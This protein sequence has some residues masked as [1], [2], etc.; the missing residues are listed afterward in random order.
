MRVRLWAADFSDGAAQ[1][2]EKDAREILPDT[3]VPLHYDLQLSPNAAAL[4]FSG[5][6][7]ITVQVNAPVNEITVNADGL[8]F[9]NATLDQTALMLTAPDAKLGRETMRA[10]KPIAAGQ[11]ILT[12]DYSGP[13]TRN[14]LGFFAMDYQSASGPRRTLATNLE[15]TGARKVLP[16][17]DEPA[18]KATFTI[19]VDAPKSDGRLQH[20]VDQVT[21]LPGDLQRVRFKQTPK[22]STYLLF[23]S[24]GDYER[25]KESRWRRNRRG[26]QARRH[27][28]GGL[29]ARSGG[30]ILHYYN[31]DLGVRLP[32][33]KLQ[34]HRRAR[35]DQRRL[36]G[37]LGRD[38]LFAAASSVRSQDVYRKRPPAGVHGRGP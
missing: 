25:V 34:S 16:C 14:T 1:A 19:S 27:R 13:I 38:F 28:Q 20:A 6:V 2:A 3:V 23:L 31:S 8:T 26:D 33:P 30:K 15:P 21:L 36:D 29:C 18:R 32:L 12:I 24:V 22:M 11:H 5:H 37:E 10:A 4:N 17:W 7:A 9:A 35:R